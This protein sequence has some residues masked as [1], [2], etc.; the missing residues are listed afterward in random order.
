MDLKG[1]NQNIK[2]EEREVS[3][4]DLL[5]NI[6]SVFYFL[7]RKSLTI[8]FVGAVGSTIG[9]TYAWFKKPIYTATSTFVLEDGDKSGGL[10]Q[11]AGLASMVGLDIGSGGGGIFQGDNIIELYKSRTMIQKTLLSPVVNDS[12][13]LLIDSFIELNEF[14]D[15]WKNKPELENLNF[16]TKPGESLTRLQDSVLR[17]VVEDIT[18]D[19][20]IVNKPDKKLNILR[21]DVSSTDEGFAKNFN[22]QIVRN[23]NDFYVFT[24]TKRSLQNINIL[25]QKRDSV[26]RSLNKAIYTAAEVA[27][28]TPNLNPTRQMQRTA[29]IQRSQFSAEANKV[30][31]GELVKNLEMSKISLMKETPLIQ[32]VDSPIFPLEKTTRGYIKFPLLFG[33]LAVILFVVFQLLKH[34]WIKINH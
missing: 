33:M 1:S 23:V 10:G 14:K 34:V 28:A 15:K 12:N 30:I 7:K 9:F 26:M 27:D 31:L 11:Y 8:F 5:A 4:T 29:P 13:R 3:I 25:K 19:Y 20:L 22:D 21:V 17:E 32:M 16:R 18:K 2:M 24:K 6:K